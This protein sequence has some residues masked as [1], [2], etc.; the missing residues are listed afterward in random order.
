MKNNNTIKQTG[1]ILG[2][3]PR[4][5]DMLFLKKFSIDKFL[6]KFNF[7]LCFV[8][9]QQENRKKGS[10]CF[11]NL[12]KYVLASKQL[13]FSC[14]ISSSK[15]Q[16]STKVQINSSYSKLSEPF[17]LQ[18][19]AQWCFQTPCFCVFVARRHILRLRRWRNYPKYRGCWARILDT[20][21]DS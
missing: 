2:K 8:S 16:S 10:Y 12:I 3:K 7:K 21:L 6:F 17:Y 5:N 1:F 19:H 9:P 20:R 13:Y 14:L 4:L 18:N 11:V 15:K